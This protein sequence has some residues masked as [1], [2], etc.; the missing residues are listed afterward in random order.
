MAKAKPRSLMRM[1]GIPVLVAF[2]ETSTRY[3]DLQI[4]VDRLETQEE[5]GFQSMCLDQS[6]KAQLQRG[7]KLC[8]I[9]LTL[10]IMAVWAYLTRTET[11]PTSSPVDV[12]W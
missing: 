4:E 11:P 6:L 2:G 7:L 3:D 9:L 5:P 8:S 1:G 12:T 10:V